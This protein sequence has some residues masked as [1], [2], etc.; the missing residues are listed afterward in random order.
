MT[1]CLLSITMTRRYL[2]NFQHFS[3]E[4]IAQ[5]TPM[6]PEGTLINIQK[7]PKNNGVCLDAL[8]IREPGVNI[9]PMIYL[10][11]YYV[12]YKDGTLLDEI[13]HIICDVFLEVRLNHP[14]DP[15]FFTD[16][17]QAKKHLVYQLISYA[18]NEERLCELPHIRY[19]DLAIVFCCMMQ[20][21][22]GENATILIRN[23]HLDLWHTDLE[24]IKKQAFDNTPRLL[25]AYIQPI[26]DA[27]CDL[28]E[29]NESLERLLPLI[30][31]DAAPPLYV[32]T[33][34]TQIYGAAC[35][36]YPS[37]LADFAESIGKDL[38]ILPSS[39]HEVL[40]LPTDVRCADK[41]LCALVRSV[42]SEQLPPA[43]QLSDTIYYYSREKKALIL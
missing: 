25:P 26:A 40:L 3:D 10:E 29:A 16:F 32:L 7:V 12:L 42:N 2:M 27:I 34:E 9:S 36:L 33:N 41:E 17:E 24:T 20:L 14:V 4:L 11:D 22:N 37:L 15:R 30:D 8:I 39:I 13:C 23:E 35:M 38:Y 21:E 5:L 6:F 1:L 18:K 19:L 31:R 43:Q 28:M